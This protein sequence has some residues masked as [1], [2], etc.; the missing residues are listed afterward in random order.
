MN[1]FQS[2]EGECAAGEGHLPRSELD[3][4]DTV[5][6]TCVLPVCIW[7]S[8]RN[9]DLTWTRVP[10]PK[11]ITLGIYFFSRYSYSFT[12]YSSEKVSSQDIFPIVL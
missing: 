4:L 6:L 12:S 3:T 5:T 11:T 7:S 8:R 1:N 10:S 9:A 2:S